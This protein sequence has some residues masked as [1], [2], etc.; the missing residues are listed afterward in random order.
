MIKVDC[1]WHLINVRNNS[2]FVVC[3]GL[4]SLLEKLPTRNLSPRKIAPRKITPKK[5]FCE[6][7]LFLILFYWV[8]CPKFFKVNF[9]KYIFIFN[10]N[11]FFLRLFFALSDY[12]FFSATYSYVTNNVR[13]LNQIGEILPHVMGYLIGKNF[14]TFNFCG[15]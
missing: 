2:I 5:L 4:N 11:W 14:I 8:F 10:K 12:F 1:F 9:S 15:L 13:L 7:C 6:F 3:S